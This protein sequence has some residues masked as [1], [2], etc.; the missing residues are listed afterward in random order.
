MYEKFKDE[1]NA[2]CILLEKGVKL[3]AKIMEA[4]L[5]DFETLKPFVQQNVLLL[6]DK[7]E[8]ASKVIRDLDWVIKFMKPPQS[9][10]GNRL[11]DA[12]CK[13]LIE[14]SKTIQQE[15][16]TVARCVKAA[17]DPP[18]RKEKAAE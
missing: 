7:Q 18:P 5:D 15:L 17:Q 14:I 9:E 2:Q 10:E 11:E 12:H 13:K 3:T 8:F 16:L 1:L 4:H 6:G